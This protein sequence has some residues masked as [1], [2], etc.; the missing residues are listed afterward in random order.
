M[1]IVSDASPLINLARI[2]QLDLL[3]QLFEELFIPEA[4]WEEV[5]IQG[6][7]QAGADEVKSIT[8]IEKRAIT[9]L[10]LV[11]PYAKSWTPEKPRPSASRW[12]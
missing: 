5:V 11:K 10:T 6:T 4:V 1:K 9:N 12:K 8:W 3:R 2:D 7:G